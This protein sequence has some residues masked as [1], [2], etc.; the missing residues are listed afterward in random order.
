M[1][2]LAKQML[3]LD[4]IVESMFL[5]LEFCFESPGIWDI[6]TMLKLILV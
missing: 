1:Q 2:C 3:M 5:S 6:S 4:F